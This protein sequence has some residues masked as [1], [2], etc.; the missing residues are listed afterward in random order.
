LT[1]WN[2]GGEVKVNKINIQEIA[3]NIFNNG[4]RS[5]DCGAREEA[6]RYGNL[7]DKILERLAEIELKHLNR[8]GAK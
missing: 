4:G 2:K 6:K 8:L 3:T 5:R 7:A 1:G